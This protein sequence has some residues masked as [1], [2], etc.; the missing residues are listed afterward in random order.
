MPVEEIRP[1]G[2]GLTMK[3]LEAWKIEVDAAH[4]RNAAAITHNLEQQKIVAEFLSKLGLTGYSEVDRKSRSRWP[5]TIHHDAGYI[6]DLRR[7]YKRVDGYE[8]AIYSYN[9]RKADLERRATEL[10]IETRAKARK[11]EAESKARE[12][13]IE[14]GKLCAKHQVECASW[15]E[16]LAFLRGKDRY[17]NLAV[18]GQMLRNDWSESPWAA[19]GALREFVPQNDIDSAIVAEWE[20]LLDDFDDGR[21]FRDC[22]YNYGVLVDMADSDLAADVRKAMDQIDI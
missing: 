18:G 3:E 21:C 8:G 20:S 4:E 10:E 17:L 11:L 1:P 9:S 19:R 12:S 15:D 16:M 13:L 14:L 2:A 7:A 5:K 22:E 6:A